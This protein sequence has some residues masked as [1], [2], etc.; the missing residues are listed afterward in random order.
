MRWMPV[1]YQIADAT[2]DMDLISM[3]IE[4]AISM[5]FLRAGDILIL[6]LD[7][8]VN[9]TEGKK[10]PCLRNIQCLS[11][12][13]LLDIAYLTIHVDAGALAFTRC[14][15]LPPRHLPP[16]HFGET[17]NTHNTT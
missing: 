6:V 12:S 13:S 17:S 10:I 4:A 5:R 9:H 11:F 7:N 14:K 15:N 16:R 1:Q 8:D 2:V 3:E